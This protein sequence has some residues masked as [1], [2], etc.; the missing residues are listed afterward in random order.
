[1]LT[2]EEKLAKIYTVTR[3]DIQRL[4]HEIFQQGAMHLAV[5]GPYHDSA[6]FDPLLVKP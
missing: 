2:P 6:E 4:A 1:M 3:E 5:I